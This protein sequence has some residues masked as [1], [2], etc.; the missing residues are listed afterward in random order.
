LMC[1]NS[2]MFQ[3]RHASLFCLCCSLLFDT[4]LIF[5]IAPV[6]YTCISYV[7][8]LSKN[9]SAAIENYTPLE[10]GSRLLIISISGGQTSKNNNNIYSR[11]MVSQH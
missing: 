6:L 7:D 11:H 8:N 1:V 9:P 2:F 4:Y 5:D 3:L 10:Q